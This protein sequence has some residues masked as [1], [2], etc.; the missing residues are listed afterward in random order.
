MGENRYTYK[1]LVGKPEGKRRLKYI[2]VD[3]DFLGR[4]KRK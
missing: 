2:H 4:M 3:N 1:M